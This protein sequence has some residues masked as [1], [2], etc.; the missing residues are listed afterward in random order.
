MKTAERLFW[1]LLT[2]ALAGAFAGAAVHARRLTDALASERT[3]HAETRK[4]LMDQVD[5]H[6]RQLLLVHARASEL[7]RA[8]RRSGRTLPHLPGTDRVLWWG[9]KR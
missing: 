6:K 2:C 7:E 9:D 5:A 1:Y 8:L 4:V 3:R